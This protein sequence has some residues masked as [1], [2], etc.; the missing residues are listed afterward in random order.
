M[1]THV[2]RGIHIIVPIS[3]HLGKVLIGK[4][5]RLIVPTESQLCLVLALIQTLEYR[6]SEERRVL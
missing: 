2:M 4:Y 1:Y 5:N 3:C 6:R